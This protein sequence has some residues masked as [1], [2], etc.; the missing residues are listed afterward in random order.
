MLDIYAVVIGR[1][2]RLQRA[3][4]LVCHGYHFARQLVEP[5]HVRSHAGWKMLVS[6]TQCAWRGSQVGE[7]RF[8]SVA[9]DRAHG[10]RR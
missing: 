6:Q 9:G 4:L 10:G 7:K 1:R 8:L 2:W 3:K 5:G